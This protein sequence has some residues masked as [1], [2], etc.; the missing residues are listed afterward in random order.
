MAHSYPIGAP[1]FMPERRDQFAR[2]VREGLA[3]VLEEVVQGLERLDAERSPEAFLTGEDQILRWF[4]VAASHVV[5]GL[6]GYVLVVKDLASGAVLGAAP[7]TTKGLEEVAASLDRLI[8]EHGAPLAIKGDQA[9][10]GPIPEELARRHRLRWLTSPGA[11]PRYNGSVESTIGWLSVHADHLARRAGR[12]G[13]W[14]GED[15]EEARRWINTARPG[16]HRPTAE[17]AFAARRPL[18]ERERIAFETTCESARARV[19]QARH[20]P[21]EGPLPAREQEIVE[22]RAVRDALLQLG[23][24]TMSRRDGLALPFSPSFVRQNS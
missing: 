14:S 22:R 19:R 3:V 11:T 20:L 16:Y 7:F 10:R 1:A 12:E 21:P 6:V 18:E 15:L 4:S 17:E 23:Y 2:R 9:F 5:A 8:A 13:R 24:L